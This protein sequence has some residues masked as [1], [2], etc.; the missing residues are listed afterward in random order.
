MPKSKKKSRGGV[1]SLFTF[2]IIFAVFF[3][4]LGCSEPGKSCSEELDTL[5]SGQPR[6]AGVIYLYGTEEGDESYLSP[7]TACALYGEGA[8]DLLKLCGDFAIFLAERP[9]PFEAA[10]FRCYSA[11]DCDRVAAA[12]LARI[13]DIRI[14]LR[15]TELAGAYDTAEVRIS[16]RIVTMRAGVQN[17]SRYSQ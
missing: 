1:R 3:T 14:T 2:T 5:L 8:G 13:D 6:P 7:E 4:L 9:N 10:V 15:D 12:L 17:I 16:G 11:S